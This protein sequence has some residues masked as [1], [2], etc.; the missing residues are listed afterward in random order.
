MSKIECARCKM[1]VEE[2]GT[3]VIEYIRYCKNCVNK[4]KSEEKKAKKI[5][6]KEENKKIKEREYSN[7]DYD[8][9]QGLISSIMTKVNITGTAVRLI[10]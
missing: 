10:Q 6:K 9:K 2:L 4:L 3:E 1:K 5:A 8:T 7:F